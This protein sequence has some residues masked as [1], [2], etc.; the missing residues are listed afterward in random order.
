MTGTVTTTPARAGLRTRHRR[1]R[2]SA[3][4]LPVPAAI[5]SGT[6]AV[7]ALWWTDTTS[8]AGPAGR[9]AGAGRITALPAGYACAVVLRLRVTAVR[10]GAPG[11]V[12][13]RLIGE[14]PQGLGGEPGRSP[15]AARPSVGRATGGLPSPRRPAGPPATAHP[16]IRPP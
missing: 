8:V 4:P 15:G 11:V 13:A 16:R 3:V 10:P 14:H 7:T 12:P 6:A 2:H 9:P 5:R 1:P